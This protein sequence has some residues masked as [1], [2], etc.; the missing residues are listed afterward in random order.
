MVRFG[1][2]S[3]APLKIENSFTK[4][5]KKLVGSVARQLETFTNNYATATCLHNTLKKKK[6]P[7]F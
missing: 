6:R 1:A 4:K 7:H 3:D 5:K 2:L